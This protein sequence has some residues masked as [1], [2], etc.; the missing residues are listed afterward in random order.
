M[1][2]GGLN[3]YPLFKGGDLFSFDKLVYL[4]QGI[5][6]YYC[7]R[8]NPIPLIKGGGYISCCEI[9]FLLTSGGGADCENY[10]Y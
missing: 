1:S 5:D 9:F 4:S 3:L 2:V 10:S 8:F 7:W 6:G